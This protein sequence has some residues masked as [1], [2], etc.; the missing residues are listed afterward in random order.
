MKLK[1]LM[2]AYK[3]PIELMVSCGLFLRQTNPNW[4][5]RIM[6]D[7]FPPKQVSEIMNLFGDERI[8]FEYSKE[9]NGFW[10]HINRKSMLE[11][12]ECEDTDFVLMTNDDN[13]IVPSFVEQMLGVVTEKTGL[14]MCDMLHSYANYEY[15]TTRLQVGFVDMASFI[16]RADVAK[17]IGFQHTSEFCG[18]GLYAIDCAKYCIDKGLDILHLP[19]AIFTHC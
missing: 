5:L 11:E 13:I 18:D 1:V 19:R 8:H 12:L 10:G 17:A 15:K 6:H 14:V 7:G 3:R 9:R 16:V 4:D 2:V